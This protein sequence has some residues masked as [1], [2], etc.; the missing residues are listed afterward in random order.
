MDR[1][2]TAV[3]TGLVSCSDSVAERTEKHGLGTGGE[4]GGGG[5]AGGW[6]APAYFR[7]D[8]VDLVSS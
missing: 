7:V 3:T 2:L 5:V 8:L 1:G 6:R 4:D